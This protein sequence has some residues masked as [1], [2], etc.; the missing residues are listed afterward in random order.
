VVRCV[1]AASWPTRGR[2]GLAYG[3]AVEKWL[4]G[5]AARVGMSG[6][7]GIGLRYRSRYVP[8]WKA[9]RFPPHRHHAQWGEENG[10]RSNWLIS[11]RRNHPTRR[12]MI[13]GLGLGDSAGSCWGGTNAGAD[14]KCR[15]G[16]RSLYEAG[17]CLKLAAGNVT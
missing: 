16:H 9:F 10:P 5:G 11:G 17:R 14:G 1:T 8:T 3:G 12:T 4:V 2:A 6:P 7:W 15:G 13:D